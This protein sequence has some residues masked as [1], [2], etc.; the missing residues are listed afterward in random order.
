[1]PAFNFGVLSLSRE[2]YHQNLSC[3]KIFTR[4]YELKRLSDKMT[5][6]LSPSQFTF[7]FNDECY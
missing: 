6:N 1:M 7:P 3:N 4:F 2:C 5:R